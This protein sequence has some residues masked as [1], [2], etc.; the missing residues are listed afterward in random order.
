MS[1][2]GDLIGAI[3]CLVGAGYVAYIREKKWLKLSPS[4]RKWLLF[5]TIF[6]AAWGFI[7]ALIFIGSSNPPVISN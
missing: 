6:L 2:N 1:H 5:S 3:E 4:K 7:L